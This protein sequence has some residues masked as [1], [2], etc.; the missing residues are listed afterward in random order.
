M[1]A[2]NSAGW[3]VRQNFLAQ[4][5]ISREQPERDQAVRLAA[6]H[7]LGE[8]EGAVIGL[9]GQPLEAAPDQEFQPSREIV[10]AKERTTVDLAGREILNLRDLLDEA[11]ARDDSARSA[12]LFN[13]CNR[14]L[15]AQCVIRFK[16]LF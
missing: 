9:A 15:S 10:A 2:P 3:R 8:I 13:G 14:H 12:E 11:V 16:T 7:R 5:G 4:G 1:A 6:A